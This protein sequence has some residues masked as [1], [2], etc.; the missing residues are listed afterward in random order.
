MKSPVTGVSFHIRFTVAGSIFSR[1]HTHA[2]PFIT[3]TQPAS[4][5]SSKHTH[6]HKM[7][8]HTIHILSRHDSR[9][10]KK[11]F[12]QQVLTHTRTQK[13][14]KKKMI[15]SEKNQYFNPSLFGFKS[16]CNFTKPFSKK[17]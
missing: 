1:A 5:Y 11:T 2:A 13:R 14:K 17:Q 4:T 3:L 10:M 12:T 9:G 16:K 7:R 15:C 6:T 8:L